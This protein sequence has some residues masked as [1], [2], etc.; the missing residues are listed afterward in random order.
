MIYIQDASCSGTCIKTEK[1]SWYFARENQNLYFEMR[2]EIFIIEMMLS[3]SNYIKNVVPTET[4][5]IPK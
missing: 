2:R 3:S 4:F 1:A 5:L